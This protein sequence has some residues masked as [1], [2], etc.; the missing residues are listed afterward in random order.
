MGKGHQFGKRQWKK[1]I[2]GSKCCLNRGR[3]KTGANMKW[4]TCKFI[5]NSNE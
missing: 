2:L 3:K 1:L 4:A 5:R